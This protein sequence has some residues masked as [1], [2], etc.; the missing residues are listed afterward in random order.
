LIDSES[1]PWIAGHSAG[2][3]FS[4]LSAA[5]IGATSALTNILAD[6]VSATEL[7]FA[8][9]VAGLFFLTPWVAK[10]LPMLA[11]TNAS[12]VWL[13]AIAGAISIVCF[14]WN[15]QHADVGTAHILFNFSLIFVLVAEYVTGKVQFSYSAATCVVMAAIGIAT[16]WYGGKLVVDFGVW[17]IGLLGAASATLAYIA[18][19]R[20]SL[21]YDPLLI[22]WTLSLVLIP[23]SLLAKSGSWVIPSGNTLL[24]LIVISLGNLL[25]QFLLNLSF[26]RLPLTVA[27]AIVPSCVVWGV[28]IV[29]V[30]QHVVLSPHAMVGMLIY[31]ISMGLLIVHSKKDAH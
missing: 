6:K 9:G 30:T 25:A 28:L 18:L 24:I 11:K 17:A 20:A 7:A 26:K 22:L 12:A 29:E 21:K 3:T 10:R 2:V 27:T 16:Y 14:I 13:R 8:L 19:S 5:C 4:I 15:L 31:A 1:Q 23:V